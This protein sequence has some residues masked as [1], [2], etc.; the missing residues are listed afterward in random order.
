[1]LTVGQVRVP[2]QLVV[3]GDSSCIPTSVAETGL[4]LPLGEL[5]GL[6]FDFCWNLKSVYYALFLSKS[7]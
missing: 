6:G 3:E 7:L 5:S 2:K 4:K 1:M